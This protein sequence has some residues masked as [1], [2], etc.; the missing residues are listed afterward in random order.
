MKNIR[1]TNNS[2]NTVL[3]MQNKLMSTKA[4]DELIKSGV[5]GPKYKE[6]LSITDRFYVEILRNI[7][8]K[9]WQV[10][11]RDYYTDSELL[12]NDIIINPKLNPRL[13]REIEYNLSLYNKAK[14]EDKI[15]I[16]DAKKDSDLLFK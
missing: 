2:Q 7:I 12:K 5:L 14:L 13:V 15:K 3:S 16:L 8:G 1:N 9:K 6:L 4:I 10:L 11:L